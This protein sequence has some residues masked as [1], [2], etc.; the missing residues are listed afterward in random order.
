MKFSGCRREAAPA[1]DRLAF[2]WLGGPSVEE[3]RALTRAQGVPCHD[4]PEEAARHLQTE[5]QR[6]TRLIT[7]RGIHLD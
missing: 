5:S 3:A 7:E 1:R 6:W 2:A 4:T